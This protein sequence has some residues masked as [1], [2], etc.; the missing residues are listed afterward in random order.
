MKDDILMLHCW[1]VIKSSRGA[2]DEDNTLLR[3]HWF[4]IYKA[5]PFY[6]SNKADGDY[7]TPEHLCTETGDRRRVG[8]TFCLTLYLNLLPLSPFPTRPSLNPSPSQTPTQLSL[9]FS[10][11]A[12]ILWKLHL[13]YNKLKKSCFSE[14]LELRKTPFWIMI[15][16]IH[17]NCVLPGVIVGLKF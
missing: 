4:Y 12:K 2:V 3:R 15:M 6:H 1:E 13:F 5:I 7:P 11:G 16:R 14:H 10:C 8:D 9:Q 17:N